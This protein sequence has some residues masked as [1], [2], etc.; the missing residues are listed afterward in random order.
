MSMQSLNAISR[1]R[2]VAGVIAALALTPS[3]AHAANATWSGA[4]SGNWSV[5]TNWSANPVPG[6]GDTATFNAASSNTV[7]DLGSGVTISTLLFGYRTE[8]GAGTKLAVDVHE[9]VRTKHCTLC[10]VL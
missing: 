6:T 10:N 9:Q 5:T 8:A 3:L 7:L 2:F 4:T 1:A